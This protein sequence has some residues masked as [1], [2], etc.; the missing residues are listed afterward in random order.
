MIG[1][2]TLL[3]KA[4][5]AATPS[6]HCRHWHRHPDLHRREHVWRHADQRRLRHDAHFG[7]LGHRQC[8]GHRYRYIRPQRRRDRQ[9]HVAQRADHAFDN[10][11]QTWGPATAGPTSGFAYGGTGS[12]NLGTGAVTITGDTSTAFTETLTANGSATLT[13]GG[14]VS[15]ASTVTAADTLAVAGLA[16][17]L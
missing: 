1:P 15:L 17:S 2:V 5:A 12:L 7:N 11:V 16:L 13:V 10:N 6:R 4:G 14:T 3:A 9:S 8:L